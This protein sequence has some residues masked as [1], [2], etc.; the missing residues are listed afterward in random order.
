MHQDGYPDIEQIDR[1]AEP[2]E[3]DDHDEPEVREEGGEA[4][5]EQRGRSIGREL[6]R[7]R[8]AGVRAEGMTHPVHQI[9]EGE[10]P[11]DE[12]EIHGHR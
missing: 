7:R 6:Q 2:D 5:H 9:R 8:V 4:D 3:A 11:D 1:I 12:G 10:H